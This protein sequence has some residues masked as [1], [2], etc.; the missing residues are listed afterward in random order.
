MKT[1]PAIQKPSSHSSKLRAEWCATTLNLKVS[2]LSKVLASPARPLN[3]ISWIITH[4]LQA[5]TYNF[6]FK[7]H[8]TSLRDGNVNIKLQVWVPEARFVGN[9]P[10]HGVQKPH[11]LNATAPAL[12]FCHLKPLL[13]QSDTE[14]SGRKSYAEE[15]CEFTGCSGQEDPAAFR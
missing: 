2:T 9:Y 14:R 8:I 4:L 11:L 6:T 10:L 5:L 12:L 15:L 3:L 1:Y 7:G 13:T